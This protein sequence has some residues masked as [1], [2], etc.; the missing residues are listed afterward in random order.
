MDVL[1][2][3]KDGRVKSYNKESANFTG[4]TNETIIIVPKAL[5][6]KL[7]DAKTQTV[8]EN[9]MEMRPTLLGL[10]DPRYSDVT[11]PSEKIEIRHATAAYTRKQTELGNL[12]WNGNQIKAD[13]ESQLR[14]G[15]LHYDLNNA[16]VTGP[17]DFKVATGEFI[18]LTIEQVNDLAG[19]LALFTQNAFSQEKI[20]RG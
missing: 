12:E 14:V 8:Q 20:D 2:G 16:L 1:V 11:T 15:K 13:I 5:Y 10:Q 4:G 7:L 17:V 3:I 18:S 9:V 19:T 6:K